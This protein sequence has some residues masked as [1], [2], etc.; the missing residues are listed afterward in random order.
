MLDR[1]FVVDMGKHLAFPFNGSVAYS[2][3]PALHREKSC[4]K[5]RF[6]LLGFPEDADRL[7]SFNSI[8]D[9]TNPHKMQV[10]GDS[11]AKWRRAQGGIDKGGG[12]C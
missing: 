10:C 9:S 12:L 3:P 8:N 7:H 4:T 1:F 11:A 2:G 6:A 5:G